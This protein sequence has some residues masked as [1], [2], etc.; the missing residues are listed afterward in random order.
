M[1]VHA[2]V[3]CESAKCKGAMECYC[4]TVATASKGMI[5][6]VLTSI[7]NGNS[8]KFNISEEVIQLLL[9]DV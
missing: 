6:K 4:T 2:A 8:E 9:C 1:Q 5:V 7:L 3:K